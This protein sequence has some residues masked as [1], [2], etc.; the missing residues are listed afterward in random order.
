MNTL[1]FWTQN[2]EPSPAPGKPQPCSIT[3]VTCSLSASIPRPVSGSFLPTQ[4]TPWT[5]CGALNCVCAHTRAC[6][7]SSHEKKKKTR[8]RRTTESSC[9]LDFL[10][11]LRRGPPPREAVLLSLTFLLSSQRPQGGESFEAGGLSCGSR[12]FLSPTSGS[13]SLHK[14]IIRLY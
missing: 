6:A 11:S 3:S 12:C 13:F 8:E 9:P 5:G 2:S 7:P 4:H 14:A 10:L 1:I